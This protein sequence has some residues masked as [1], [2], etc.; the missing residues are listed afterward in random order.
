[1]G[2]APTVFTV[3]G[4]VAAVVSAGLA[5]VGWRSR[6]K[7]YAPAFTALMVAL[8]VWAAVHG[9]QVGLTTEGERLVWM[10]LT[11]TA[12]AAVPTLWFVFAIKYA[13][14]D[15]WLTE[16][17]RWLLAVE[18]AAFAVLAVTNGTHELIWEVSR[19]NGSLQTNLTVIGEVHATYSYVLSSV[20]IVSLVVVALRGS[21]VYR[22]QAA[23]LV[24]GAGLPLVASVL[25]VTDATSM[26]LTPFAYAAT[27]VVW[28]IGLF[29]LDLL[30]RAPVAHQQAIS[31]VGDGLVVFDTAGQVVHVDG[32]AETVFDPP[33]GV[34]DSVER[35]QADGGFDR[36][37]IDLPVEQPT[38]EIERTT[39]HPGDLLAD[40]DG[41]T[42]TAVVGGKQR[43][44]DLRVSPLSDHRDRQTGFLL[45]LRD[46][47]QREAYQQRL[48]VTNR[49]L[50]HNLRNEMNVVTGHAETI[51]EAVDDAA[52]VT[53]AA[54]TIQETADGLLDT[55]RK[56]RAM[57]QLPQTAAGPVEI[58]EPTEAIVESFRA[59]HP[60]AT[61]RLDLPASATATVGGTD[62]YRI[63][64]RNLIENAIQHHDGTPTVWV[65]VEA[66]EPTV[67]EVADDGPGVPPVERETF[68]AG[69]ETDL[70]H[71]SGLGLWL[72]YWVTNGAGGELTFRD[73]EPRGSIIS[74]SFPT[75]E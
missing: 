34:G 44:Y 66:G 21:V 60:E 2:W 1:M 42:Q 32:V 75:D 16:W 53:E 39:A 22:R 18:P 43:A 58:T 8:G 48:E 24:G 19:A 30:N 46:V 45:V 26:D 28:G 54:V 7:S 62:R 20:A 51:Q 31:E 70:Q 38:E 49:V 47:T 57:A 4:V 73:R 11:S 50:R 64:V 27:G 37:E 3:S 52:S 41:T 69:K 33:L 13:G 12:S 5:V 17:R 29:R 67:V 15:G 63:A 6:S 74:M 23:L 40:V 59:A 10:Q 71:A 9:F 36:S 65:S 72:V 56:A 55:S 25:A 35:L 61:I 14:F 68:A